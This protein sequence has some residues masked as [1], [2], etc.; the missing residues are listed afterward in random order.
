[1]LLKDRNYYK[2]FDYPWAYEVLAEK[3]FYVGSKKP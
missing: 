2:P 3:G 1:M